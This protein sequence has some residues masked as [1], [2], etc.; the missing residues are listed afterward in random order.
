NRA[1]ACCGGP[2]GLAPG[3]RAYVRWQPRVWGIAHRHHMRDWR[4][5]SRKKS[6]FREHDS[7]MTDRY[8]RQ[9]SQL[10]VLTDD[11]LMKWFSELWRRSR[12]CRDICAAASGPG[13]EERTV[14]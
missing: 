4:T 5:G 10:Y 7:A 1:L 6:N 12:P 11:P 13:S 9:L 3:A 2:P 14:S 8:R